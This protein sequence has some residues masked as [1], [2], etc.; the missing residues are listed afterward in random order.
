VT[1]TLEIGKNA[2]SGHNRVTVDLSP[3]FLDDFSG[4]QFSP[5]VSLGTAHG[6]SG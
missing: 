3:Q 6:L 5:P 1:F 2:S 4:R